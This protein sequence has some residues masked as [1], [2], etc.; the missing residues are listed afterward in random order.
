MNIDPSAFDITGSKDYLAAV[1]DLIE[2]M[3]PLY[4]KYRGT[5]HLKSYVKKSETDFGTWFPFEEYD[6]AVAYPPKIPA[7]PLAAGVVYELAP[8][9]F[10]IAGM[11]S[12]LTFRPKEG[13]NFRVDYLKIEEGT[14]EKGNWKPG[15]I[16]NG[17]ERMAIRLGDMPTCLFIELYKY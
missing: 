15:R 6:L 12:T 9:K 2:Q 4:L 14:L 7:K 13:E 3:K 1:Y 8:N 5:E 11:M 10:L 16:L 17:D